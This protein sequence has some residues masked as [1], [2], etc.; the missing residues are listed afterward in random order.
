MEVAAINSEEPEIRISDLRYIESSNQSEMK[1]TALQTCLSNIN[2]CCTRWILLPE[3][4]IDEYSR[5]T[6]RSMT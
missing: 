6:S 4:M 3:E 5:G 1:R 2:T